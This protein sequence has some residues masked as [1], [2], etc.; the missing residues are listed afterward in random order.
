MQMIHTIAAPLQPRYPIQKTHV[1]SKR[2]D[3]HCW[4]P[5]T[6]SDSATASSKI[7]LL[8]Q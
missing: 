7:S 8:K 3:V 2:T 4:P 5:Q 6:S 1:E